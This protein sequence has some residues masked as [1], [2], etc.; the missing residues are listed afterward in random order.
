MLVLVLGSLVLEL[1]N[2]ADADSD[3]DG[4]LELAL[5]LAVY[6]ARLSSRQH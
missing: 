3:T 1:L 5:E 6:E 2:V 4:E